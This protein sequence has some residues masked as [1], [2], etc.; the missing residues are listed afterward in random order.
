MPI[1][2]DDLIPANAPSQQ[3]TFDDLVPSQQPAQELPTD[4][5][6][7]TSRV[8]LRDTLRVSRPSGVNAYEA[9]LR[10]GSLEAVTPQE[11]Q[12]LRGNPEAYKE[13]LRIRQQRAQEQSAAP[14]RTGG[15]FFGEMI[16]PGGS[17]AAPIGKMEIQKEVEPY[18][19]D[20]IRRLGELG[21]IKFGGLPIADVAKL[22]LGRNLEEASRGIV[23]QLF[24][25]DAAKTVK[26]VKPEGTKAD[27]N[28]QKAESL[29]PYA[30]FK[31]SPDS[32]YETVFDPRQV[33]AGGAAASAI[34]ASPSMVAGTIGGVGG[35]FI[36]PIV[37]TAIGTGVASAI[38]DYGRLAAGQKL[39]VIPQNVPD[40]EL[41][42]EA[43][44]RGGLDALF[45]AGGQI[46]L[47][48]IL[49]YAKRGGVPDVG[50]AVR[51]IEDLIRSGQIVLRGTERTLGLPENTLQTTVGSLLSR[52]PHGAVVQELERALAT[53]P[54]EGG[55]MLRAQ[56]DAVRA[57]K[58][59]MQ[60]APGAFGANFETTA[61]LGTRMSPSQ[62]GE[63]IARIAPG[64]PAEVEQTISRM[65]RA[66]P[67]NP[68][69]GPAVPFV[70][71]TDPTAGSSVVNALANAEEAAK[72]RVG[73]VL[74]DV[75]NVVGG[76][77]TGPAT[78]ARTAALDEQAR[79][80][81]NRISALDQSDQK[82]ISDFLDNLKK[83]GVNFTYDEYKVTLESL[84][85]AI[86]KAYGAQGGQDAPNVTT[87][88]RLEESL[89]A[90]RDELV[91]SIGGKFLVDKIRTAESQYR[92]IMDGFRRT[93]LNQF[94]GE[95]ARGADII[96]DASIGARIL[97]DPESAQL[98]SNIV[99]SQSFPIE[100]E[101]I[102]SMLRFELARAGGFLEAKPG[103]GSIN[104]AAYAKYLEDKR[105]ILKQFFSDSEISGLKSIGAW[106]Q[107]MRRLFG[108][109]DLKGMQNW[110]DD[111]WK[112]SDGAQ[113]KELMNRLSRYDRNNPGDGMVDTVRAYMRNRMASEITDPPVRPGDMPMVNKDKLFNFLQKHPNR[114]EWID[115][116][117]DPQFSSR[118]RAIH[119]AL[120]QLEPPASGVTVGAAGT[121]GRRELTEAQKA[122]TIV[123]GT[124]N[125]V[126]AF[127]NRQINSAVPS[128]QKKFARA[129]VDPDY[130]MMLVK[131]GERTA[132][133]TG[134]AN[135]LAVGVSELDDKEKRARQISETASGAASAAMNAIP[136]R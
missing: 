61:L 118:M 105:P 44:K 120:L 126:A 74:Q 19:A 128:I 116:V 4:F 90:D 95:T 37:G 42:M 103:P 39:G 2:F 26:I 16:A 64:S 38:A 8:P 71:P 102:R 17:P 124:L 132:G 15:R 7:P 80:E 111:F 35:S 48:I 72:A 52:S 121:V 135:A 50:M 21:Q 86:R 60:A 3:L 82:V 73:Y 114:I 84:R 12:A 9:Y 6:E 94:I 77:S 76:K 96:G 85:R 31:R 130:F 93:K 119:Q 25:A 89:S 97:R 65:A 92:E 98:V 110:F 58:E 11:V 62:L 33:T 24:G 29:Q 115:A 78:N 20:A 134:T 70:D 30:I 1:E 43:M 122:K 79:G 56:M 83:K 101:Q 41:V 136:G 99:N 125:R 46:A 127:V 133:R 123:F 113:A 14:V 55:A 36:S 87:L 32:P 68:Q 81:L 40:S 75:R 66:R 54:G 23:E 27:Q 22:G 88:L 57:G 109:E 67:A 51:E 59:A 112:A 5:A 45:S 53:T 34:E 131:A 13:L 104:A 106:S 91:K 63:K 108:V 49:K 100:R 69:Y 129:M 28:G 18:E 117:I 107:R 47:G 10:G